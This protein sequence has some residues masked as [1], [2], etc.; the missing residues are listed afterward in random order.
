MHPHFLFNS[1]N[2]IHSLMD[3]SIEKSKS[4]VVDLSDLLRNVLD[5]KDQNLIELQEELFI[6][7]KYIHIKETRFSDQLDIQLNVEEGLENILVPNMLIQPIVENS[8]KH[9][10]GK[11][12]IS[13]NSQSSKSTIYLNLNCI[14]YR[15]QI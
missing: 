7:K 4:M 14:F 12:H 11:E 2:S 6:L 3:I 9:G 10:Y 13:L 1:L 5:K 8:T 15:E